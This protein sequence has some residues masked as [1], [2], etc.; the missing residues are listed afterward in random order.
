M[1]EETSR[2]S[3]DELEPSVST[4]EFKLSLFQKLVVQLS[5]DTSDIQHEKL[6]LKLVTPV[7]PEFS[8][9]PAPPV[10]DDVAGADAAKYSTGADAA[11]TPT[12]A[13]AAKS[14]ASADAAKTPA[15]VDAAKTPA[16]A[17]ATEN[18]PIADNNSKVVK[19]KSK[20]EEL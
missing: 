6:T 8:V 3:F 1:G 7:I 20:A 11:K 17:D 9:P 15:S 18:L 12:G 16:S 13:D 4:G 5:L 14:S 19:R 2:W 10:E